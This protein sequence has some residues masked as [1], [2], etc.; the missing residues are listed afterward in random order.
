M[1]KKVLIKY[2]VSFGE[3]VVECDSYQAAVELLNRRLLA[4]AY[5]VCT[6]NWKIVEIRK[7]L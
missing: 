2:G 6:Q 7:P 3:H 5:S 1:A 4:M